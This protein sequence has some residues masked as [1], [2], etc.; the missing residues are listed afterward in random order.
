MSCFFGRIYTEWNVLKAAG[1]MTDARWPGARSQ[2]SKAEQRAYASMDMV[3]AAFLHAICVADIE[4]TKKELDM[5]ADSYEIL[6]KDLQ[7]FRNQTKNKKSDVT[8]VCQSDPK[9]WIAKDWA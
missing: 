2:M 4:K 7:N 1:E 3:S 5:T 8:A 9:E 6:V